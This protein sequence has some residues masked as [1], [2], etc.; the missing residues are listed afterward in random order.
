MRETLGL[1]DR[2]Y[3]IHSGRVLM[4]GSPDEIIANEDVRGVSGRELP[5]LGADGLCA[6]R[7]AAAAATLPFNHLKLRNRDAA[8]AAC[9][10][11]TGGG[12]AAR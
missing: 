5:A 1:V 8:A 7:G 10:G 6:A 2:A 11:L 3:I 9:T 12:T 4:E